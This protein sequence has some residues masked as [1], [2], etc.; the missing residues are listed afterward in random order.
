MSYQLKEV[1]LNYLNEET[2]TRLSIIEIKTLPKVMIVI[3][4]VN[5]EIYQNIE[6][7]ILKKTMTQ[8]EIDKLRT[9]ESQQKRIVFE[10]FLKM[11]NQRKFK[12]FKLYSNYENLIKSCEIKIR[13]KKIA[14]PKPLI[15]FGSLLSSNNYFSGH[16][17][18][19]NLI[20]SFTKQLHNMDIEKNLKKISFELST[21]SKFNIV[22]F[23]SF[24]EQ[25]VKLTIFQPDQQTNTFFSSYSIQNL[26]KRDKFCNSSNNDQIVYSDYE[27]EY[28]RSN[29][30][31]DI[32][33]R[34]YQCLTHSNEIK[35]FD[36]DEHLKTKNYKLCESDFVFNISFEMKSLEYCESKCDECN[37]IHYEFSSKSFKF[38]NSTILNLIPISSHHLRYTETFKMDINGLIYDLGGLLGLW[39]GISPLSLVYLYV[40]FIRFC[41]KIKQSLPKYIACLISVSRKFIT[42]PKSFITNFKDLLIYCCIKLIESLFY[43]LTPLGNRCS[44]LLDN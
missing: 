40:S 21:S 42:N 28:C 15:K 3:D 36:L 39:F 19:G 9:N 43:L 27:P 25:S 2:I 26:S 1:I 35:L 12:E 10:F 20:D 5:E 41:H 32:L 8:K 23:G 17:Y 16:F 33:I 34:E 31:I 29:C 7:N 24:S 13:N 30:L 4:L 37:S 38:I 11:L 18:F 6:H 14:C 44:D 22:C